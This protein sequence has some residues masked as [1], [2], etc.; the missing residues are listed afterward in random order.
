MLELAVFHCCSKNQESNAL[1]NNIPISALREA[2]T[3]GEIFEKSKDVW[4]EIEA[5][6]KRAA[7][8]PLL[9]THAY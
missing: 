8:Q 3:T 6:K 4:R 5:K 9:S 7:I 2:K 1:T